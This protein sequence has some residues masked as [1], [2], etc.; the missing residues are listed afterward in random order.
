[1]EKDGGYEANTICALVVSAQDLGGPCLRD[2]IRI[3]GFAGGR[4]R[5]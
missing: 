1:M 4:F 3:R 2:T 5:P